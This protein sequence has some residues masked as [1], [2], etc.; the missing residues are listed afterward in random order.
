MRKQIEVV[1][2]I[3][4]ALL[5]SLVAEAPARSG[6]VA[7]GERAAVRHVGAHFDSLAEA[8]EFSGAVLLARGDTPLL[9]RAYGMADRGAKRPNRADTKFNLGS[10]NKIFTRVAVLQLVEQGRLGLD[11]TIDHY[12]S[13][14]P[15]EKGARITVRMLLEHEG[16][17]GDIFDDRFLEARSTL[18]T[19]G[20][21]YAYVRN[22]PLDFEPGARRAYSN[23]GYILLG[24]IVSAVSGQEYDDYVRDRIFRPAGMRATAAYAMDDNVSNRAIGYTRESLEEG[25]GAAK[26][27]PHPNDDFLPA[28]GSSAGGGYSTCGDLAKFAAALK[29]G[30]LLGP[31]YTATIVEPDGAFRVAGGAP[32]VNGVLEVV[33]PY[34]LVVLAN[35]DPRGAERAA[36]RARGWIEDA[37]PHGVAAHTASAGG[38]GEP[39]HGEPVVVQRRVGGDADDPLARPKRSFVPPEGIDVPMS[40]ADHLPAV[41]VMVNGTGPYRFAIDTGGSGAVRIDSELA[42]KLGMKKVGEVKGG[43]PSGKNLVTMAVVEVDSIQLGDATFVRMD[44]ATRDYQHGGRMHGV[45]G[46]LG[47]GLFSGYTVTFDYP[48]GRLRID[49]KELPPVNGNDVLAYSDEDGVPSIAIQ[50]DSLTMPAHID[51]GSMGGFVLPERLLDKLPLSGP[52]QVIG[53][54]RTVSNT[55]EI[56]GAPMRGTLRIGGIDFVDPRLEFQPIMPDANVGSRILRGFTLSFDTRNKR[57]RFTRAS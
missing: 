34:T 4:V 23:V 49:A 33:G 14:Y 45:D 42:E 11:E 41:D 39:K 38:G 47:F 22:Q 55:F 25:D 43:D 27:D 53:T 9:E 56:K 57:V 6:P 37:L 48:A 17:T 35:Q 16:G 1:S 44:S 29:G 46:V 12:L 7:D 18:R 5:V 30:A 2:W 26:R 32:G 20:D 52:P 54:A 36:M 31:E 28:R 3:V 50:V 19:M 13:D 10:I 40:L 15:K 8:G 51:A 24:A 21:Y